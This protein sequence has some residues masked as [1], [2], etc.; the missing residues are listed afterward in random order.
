M[1]NISYD[2]AHW[3]QRADEMRAA[4]KEMTDAEAE[5]ALLKIAADYDR[6]AELALKRAHAK[7][8]ES[9]PC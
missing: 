2:S 3:Q 5:E 1:T 9:S 6:L 7:F 8:P 4:A